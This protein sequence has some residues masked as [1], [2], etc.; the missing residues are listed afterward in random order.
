MQFFWQLYGQIIFCNFSMKST[1][2]T[3]CCVS[4]GD[5]SGATWHVQATP[6]HRSNRNRVAGGLPLCRC[7]PCTVLPAHGRRICSRCE[8]RSGAHAPFRGHKLEIAAA[9]LE[10]VAF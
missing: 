3:S 6:A 1:F 7:R 2:L 4:C 8:R 10:F 5:S 9:D